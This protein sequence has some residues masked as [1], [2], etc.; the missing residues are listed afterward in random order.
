MSG[1]WQVFSARGERRGDP[2]SIEAGRSEKVRSTAAAVGRRYHGPEV[3]LPPFRDCASSFQAV[4]STERAM[5]ANLRARC[6]NCAQLQELVRGFFPG[7]EA[8]ESGDSAM[9]LHEQVIQLF[10]RRDSD[11]PFER[12]GTIPPSAPGEQP[13]SGRARWPR[14]TSAGE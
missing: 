8:C 10:K 6:A 9:T 7:I 12:D 2:T 1:G 5:R 13:R 4:G 11:Q 3:D 14:G